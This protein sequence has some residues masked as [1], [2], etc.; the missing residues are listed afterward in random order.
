MD[1]KSKETLEKRITAA[2]EEKLKDILN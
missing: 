1:I 2:V